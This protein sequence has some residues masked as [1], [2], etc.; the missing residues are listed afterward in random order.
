MRN[1][2]TKELLEDLVRNSKSWSEVCRSLGV[3]PATGAQTHVKNRAKAFG[4]DSSHFLGP[5]WNKG[6]VFPKLQTDVHSYLKKGTTVKSH[7]LRLKLIKAGL[8]QAICELCGLDSW[9]G[10][11]INLEL[12]HKNSD[13]WDNRLDNLQIVCPNCHAQETAQR[14]EKCT[15][16]PTGER[17]SLGLAEAKAIVGSTPTPCTLGNLE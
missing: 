13:H 7:T 5:A 17:A 6:Q 15:G 1:K 2:Y 8:K 4:L 12:D 10:R 14:R 11:P 16:T 9:R 3:K